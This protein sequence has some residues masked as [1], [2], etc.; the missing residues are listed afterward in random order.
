MA[1]ITNSID[2]PFGTFTRK[3]DTAYAFAAV[4]E[5]AVN[6]EQ[7]LRVTGNR[8]GDAALS[9]PDYLHQGRSYPGEQRVRYHIVWSRTEAGARKNAESYVWQAARCAGVFPVATR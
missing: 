7:G 2:T 5:A 9:D 3:S 8:K 6:P 4:A 1:K